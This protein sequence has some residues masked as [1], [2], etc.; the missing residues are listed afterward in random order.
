LLSVIMLYAAS[1]FHA[2]FSGLFKFIKLTLIKLYFN[3]VLE[4]DILNCSYSLYCLYSYFYVCVQS[5]GFIDQVRGSWC[6]CLARKNV[7]ILVPLRMHACTRTGRG[8][9]GL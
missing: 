3:L 1:L 7:C 9:G 5:S 2:M 4:W 6:H 8:G